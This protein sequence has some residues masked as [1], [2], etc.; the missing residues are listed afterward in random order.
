MA[1]C[2]SGDNIFG[3]CV[4]QSQQYINNY[5]SSYNF[6]SENKKS[7]TVTGSNIEEV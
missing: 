7:P 2:K 4:V 6:N 5:Y 3:E 1:G